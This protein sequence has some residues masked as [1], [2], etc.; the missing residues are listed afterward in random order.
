MNSEGCVPRDK[1]DLEAVQRARAA[2]YPAIEPV[3]PVLLEWV[4]DLNWPVAREIAPFLVEVGA[5]IVPLILEVLRGDDS[6]WKYSV[7]TE[8][9][10]HL[11]KKAQKPLLEECLRMVETPTASEKAE[12]A[13]LAAREILLNHG[14]EIEG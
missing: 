11:D 12:E 13:D 5:P 9:V 3:L 6:I 4:Q 10:R 7:L 1:F 14:Y 2:G 8:I